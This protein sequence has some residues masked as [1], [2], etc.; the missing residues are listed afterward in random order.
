[1]GEAES[2]GWRCEEA[3]AALLRAALEDPETGWSLGSFGA[4]AIFS[5]NQAE[6]AVAPDDGRPGWVT[7]RGAMA[8]SPPAGLHPL[9]Y[10]TA[11]A[12]GWSHAVALCLAEESC[13]MAGRSVLTELGP[14]VGAARD[15]DRT[16]ILFDLGLGLRAADACLRTADPDLLRLLR[17]ATGRSLLDP[18]DP[19][20]SRATAAGPHR[21]ILT[22][23]GRIEVFG[24]DPSPGGPEAAGPRAHVLPE[25]LRTGRTH[26]ATAPIPAGLV[27]CGALHPP[28]PCR[29][30]LGRP[31]PFRRERHDA[32]QHL[33]DAWGDPALVAAKRAAEAGRG[34]PPGPGPR[35]R[36]LRAA[37]RAAEVQAPHLRGEVPGAA[38]LSDDP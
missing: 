4:L 8:L 35:A 7:P 1:M 9:A 18:G 15:Q 23:L 12:S 10:E 26:A 2:A 28:H 14:D 36:Y 16:A 22:R 32:F 30:T 25:I 17:A 29:D 34:V 20:L 27:P 21:L 37:R 11:F 31:I 6:V 3:V 5:R 33:L 24:P 13:A 38:F 19:L